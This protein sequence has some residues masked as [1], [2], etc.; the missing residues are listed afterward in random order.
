MQ[1][2]KMYAVNL[3]FCV[4][5]IDWLLSAAIV[6]RV[7]KITGKD[8]LSCRV[9]NATNPCKTVVYAL[10]VLED[11]RNHN[12]SKFTFSVEDEVYS[13]EERVRITQTS[14]TKSVNLK[15]SNSTGRSII[16]CNYTSAG[17][18]IGTRYINAKKTRNI[19]FENLEFQNCGGP[20]FAAVVLIWNSVDVNFTNC[21]FRHNTQAGINAFDSGVA[22]ESCLFLNNTF[23]GHNSSEV[24]KEGVIS[25]GGGAGFL[26]HDS[27]NISLIIRNSIFESNEAVTNDST[28]FIAPSSNVTHF[29]TGGGGLLVVFRNKARNCQVII[30]NTAFKNNTATYGAGLYLAD[31]N[32]AIRNSFTVT[33]SN[34]TGN[35]AGQ[36]GGGIIISKWD[37][38]SKIT[39]LFKNC[40]VSENESKRGAGMN[41]FLMNYDSTPNDSILRL[42][43]RTVSPQNI[44]TFHGI[45][46]NANI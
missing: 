24:Y 26:F 14:T 31:S 28:D 41:V 5:W 38:A 18:E 23:N 42:V 17:I 2:Y 40:I 8:N 32:L 19:Q 37:K 21:V 4:I 36:T 33:N 15:S 9:Q 16:R 20:H 39:T 7:S 35:R 1:S 30:D 12:E 45:S 6:V 3:V 43:Q 27:T 13:L 29:S 25:A 34:F 22:I 44:E 46:P 10:G 11:K